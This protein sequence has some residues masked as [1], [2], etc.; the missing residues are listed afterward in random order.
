MTQSFSAEIKAKEVR[1]VSVP[2]YE[3]LTI[4]KIAAFADSVDRNIFDYM[5][6]QQEIKKVS[7]EWICNVCATV[8]KNKFTDWL[9][10]M[11]EERN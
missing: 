4:M 2:A 1:H 6:D 8:L 11:I 5:P 9:S 10:K 7:K 3:N